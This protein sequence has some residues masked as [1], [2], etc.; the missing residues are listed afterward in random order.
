LEIRPCFYRPVKPQNSFTTFIQTR[1]IQYLVPSRNITIYWICLTTVIGCA[2]WHVSKR[3][4]CVFILYALNRHATLGKHLKRARSLARPGAAC[5]SVSMRRLDQHCPAAAETTIGA[6]TFFDVSEWRRRPLPITSLSHNNNNNFL[7]LYYYI[8]ILRCNAHS[9]SRQRTAYTRVIIAVASYYDMII[10][11]LLYL[12]IYLPTSLIQNIIL[13]NFE[14]SSRYKYAHSLNYIMY[15][16]NT[17]CR[18]YSLTMRLRE[19]NTQHYLLLLLHVII[20][21]SVSTYFNGRCYSL[22]KNKIV[23]S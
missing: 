6:S 15:K 11:A 2:R 4:G 3:F 9:V 17:P 8:V 14:Y 23:L 20:Y 21:F 19:Q 22:K 13:N 12:P 5:A 10:I 7:L 18:R 1:T 16:Y